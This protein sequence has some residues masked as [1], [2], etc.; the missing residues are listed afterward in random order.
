MSLLGPSLLCN[1]CVSFSLLPLVHMFPNLIYFGTLCGF[2]MAGPQR[3]L[4]GSTPSVS[5]SSSPPWPSVI[6]PTSLF[7][8]RLCMQVVEGLGTLCLPDFVSPLPCFLPPLLVFASVCPLK[9]PLKLQKSEN[10]QFSEATLSVLPYQG[11]LNYAIKMKQGTGLSVNSGLGTL[12][13]GSNGAENLNHRI[14]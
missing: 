5:L 14:I 11:A 8:C 7:V 12:A 10:L 13:E 3:A 1:L 4:K 9:K 6:A 2:A